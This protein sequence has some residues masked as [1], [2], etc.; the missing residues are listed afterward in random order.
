MVSYG[1]EGLKFDENP[2]DHMTESFTEFEY[3]HHQPLAD[4][5]LS[6]EDFRDSTEFWVVEIEDEGNFFIVLRTTEFRWNA[7]IK[8]FGDVSLGPKT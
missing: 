2:L 5:G 3:E 6:F 4:A 8:S 1:F 7:R